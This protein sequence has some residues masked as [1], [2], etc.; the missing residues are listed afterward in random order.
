MGQISHMD[1]WPLPTC[2]E[3]NIRVTYQQKDE[4]AYSV[5]PNMK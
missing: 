5:V 4:P 1:I 3:V 2:A